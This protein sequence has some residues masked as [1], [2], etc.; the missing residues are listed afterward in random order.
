MSPS[1][2]VPGE[3][4]ALEYRILGP[5]EVLRDGRPLRL[6]RPRERALLALLVLSANRVVSADALAE[7]LWAGDPPPSAATTLRVYISRLRQALGE[8]GDSLWTRPPG[9]RLQVDDEAVDALRFEA[10]CTEARQR[11]AAGDHAEAAQVLRQALGLWRGAALPEVADAPVARAEAARLEEARLAALEDRIEADVAVGNHRL[12]IGELEALTGANPLRERLWT[13]RMLALYRS[14]RHAE[15]LRAYQELRR[16]L[17]DELGL[18]P[19][20]AIRE[21][22]AAILRQDPGLDVRPPGPGEPP[23]PATSP[24]EARIPRTRGPERKQV[25][26]LFA[27]VVDSMNLTATMDLEEW[28]DLMGRFFAILRDGVTRFDGHVDKF[29]GD[30]IMALFGA[31]VAYEDHARQACAAALHLREELANYRSQLERQRGISFNVRMGLNSGEVVAGPIDDEQSLEYTAVGTTVGLAQRMESLAEPGAVYVTATT[32]ALVEGYFELRDL[33]AKEPKGSGE[34]ITVFELVG[35]GALRTPLEVAA[36]RGFSR[37]VG[38]AGEMAALEA[39]F[40]RAAEG[41]GQVVGVVAEPGVGK[42]RLCHEFAESCRARGVDVFSAHALAHASTVPFLPVLEILRAQFGITET[43]DAVTSRAA[44][45]RAVLDLDSALADSLPLLF[46]FLGVADPDRPVA[47]MDPEARQRQL[48]GALNRL[49]RA[50]SDRRVFVF[51]VEDLHWLDPGSEAFVENV[52]NATPGTRLLV[53]TTFRPEYRAP[54][55]HRSHYGQLPL[56]P[57]GGDASA[58]LL[59]DLLGPHPSLD[60]MAELV[61]ERCGG[62]PFFLQE[63]VQSLVEDGSLVGGRGAYELVRTVGDLSIP[64][65]VQAVLAARVDRLPERDKTLLQTASVI[66]RQFPGPLAGR[67][68]GLADHEL[69]AS[70]RSLVEGE[71]VYETATYPE[72]E[73]AFKHAL[74]EEVAYRSQLARHRTRTH[75]G[76]ARVLTDLDA[77]KLDERASLIAHHYELGGEL[78]EAARWNAR[79]AAWAGSSHPVEAARHW[80]RVR[81]LTDRLEP[82]AETSELGTEARWQLLGCHFRL[83]AASEEG[84]TRY[85]DEAAQV[86]DELQTFAI[87]ADRPD[88]R[89]LSLMVYGAVQNLSD[90]V[91]ASLDT[92]REATRVADS[93]GD[94]ALRAIARGGLDWCL[95][96]NGRVREAFRVT[97]E[98]EAIFGD[99]RALARGMVFTSYYAYCH[100]HLGQFGPHCGRLDDGLVALERAIEIAGEEGDLEIQAWAHRHWAIFA[101]W[102]G[103]D[104]EA[105]AAHALQALR[106]AEESGGAWSRIYVREGVATSYAQRGEWS[107][108]IEVVDEALVIARE[109]RI[110]HAN[111]PLLLSIRARALLGQGDVAAARRCAGDAV[112]TAVR[113]GTRFYEAQARHRLGRALLAAGELEAAKAELDGALSIV[114]TSGVSA[115]APQIHQELAHVAGAAGDKETCERRLR[116]AYRLF[117]EAGAPARA[118]E[119]LALVES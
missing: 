31:P 77:D 86:F 97:R 33:G 90:A 46:D 79:A 22:E 44:I 27:D 4:V 62:N 67:V 2:G 49:R 45:E 42:S 100:M 107:R 83:G 56:S 38:R 15:A 24:P 69:E 80:R 75:A 50:R 47:V 64:A 28:G 9:Y 105:A 12:V 119:A 65:T 18:E 23:A 35:R 103:T 102:A 5:L 68:A 34:P 57:L 52:V 99:N 114:E 11:A 115:Y 29:T 81:A 39:A 58:E 94:P 37:F 36:A 116:T 30:G 53:V 13:L 87:A 104:P 113:V 109:R 106:W 72:E 78:L 118:A 40:A 66:G 59:G 85:E 110:A 92:V 91:V 1:S 73:Y 16:L 93:I 7:D 63:V 8:D 21:L 3:S 20:E 54:W 61:R 117:L 108:A 26:V 43:D 111:V 14:G 25:T 95:F 48:F 19:G 17:A 60:G 89:A 82:T 88:L 112:E 70:L 55:A 41:N 74:T 6:E 32:A 51:V 71:F 98:M 96:V 10:L 76:V 84:D 101:D